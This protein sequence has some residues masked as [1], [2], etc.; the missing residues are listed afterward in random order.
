MQ[1]LGN[2]ETHDWQDKLENNCKTLLPVTIIVLQQSS[3][4]EWLTNGHPFA[5]NVQEIAPIIYKSEQFCLPDRISTNNEEQLKSLEM[6]HL[7]GLRKSKEFLA[8]SELFR[9]RKQHAMAAFMLHQSVEQSLRTILK[10]G[11]GYHS[12]THSIDRLIRYTGL[13]SYQLPDV[14]PQQTEADKRLFSLLQKAYIDPRYKE[15]YQIGNDELLQLTAKA[16]QIIMITSEV[17]KQIL[18]SIR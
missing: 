14:F 16:Q 9:I 17:G 7:E 8:G 2:K 1:D 13:V 5:A 6:F 18:S 11:T 15:G 12:N 10:I 3:F 4:E